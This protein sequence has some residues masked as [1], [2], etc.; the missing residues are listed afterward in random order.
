VR[1]DNFGRCNLWRVHCPKFVICFFSFIAE[2]RG[3]SASRLQ[4]LRGN[5]I[6]RHSELLLHQ[7]TQ[8]RHIFQVGH[9]IVFQLH[10]EALLQRGL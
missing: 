4:T 10:A 1:I 2:W 3:V 5:T 7:R 8:L 6:R 9:G